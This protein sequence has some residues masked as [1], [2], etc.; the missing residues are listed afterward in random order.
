[1]NEID[2][3]KFTWM[4]EPIAWAREMAGHLKNVDSHG[5]LVTV[6]ATMPQTPLDLWTDSRIDWVQIHAYGTD[7]SNLMFERLSP[8]QN[9][10]KPVLMGE[11]GGG[12]ESRDDIPDQDGV[13][14][15][16]SLWLTACSP[17]AGVAMPWWWDT[18]IETRNLYPVLAAAKK[19]VAGDDRRG[20]YGPW[21][22]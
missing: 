12:T 16:A 17:S 22:G 6:S 18:Y 2:L 5:H 10:A 4:D 21:V 3:A 15:Q 14:L 7:V 11:F 9:L 1:M 20:R 8:F 19:F 13:R